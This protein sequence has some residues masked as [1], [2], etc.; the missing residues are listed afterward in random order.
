MLLASQVILKEFWNN[1]MFLRFISADEKTKRNLLYY[2]HMHGRFNEYNFKKWRRL[3][4]I[5]FPLSLELYG[6]EY[7]QLGKFSSTEPK[8]RLNNYHVSDSR[9]GKV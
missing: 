3:H 8:H 7:S 1:Y 4:Q 6:V 2:Y 9:M 5:T